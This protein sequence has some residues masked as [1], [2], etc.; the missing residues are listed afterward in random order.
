VV[1]GDKP[2]I[3]NLPPELE[4]TRVNSCFDILKAIECLVYS[5]KF[6]MESQD[7]LNSNTKVV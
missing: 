1:L 4:Q 7:N 5:R 3:N 2:S 6:L